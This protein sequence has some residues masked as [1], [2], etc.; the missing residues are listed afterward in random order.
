MRPSPVSNNPI[1]SIGG[2]VIRRYEPEIAELIRA[3]DQRLDSTGKADICDDRSLEV[4]SELLI[5]RP[6]G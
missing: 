1:S 2:V 3:R 6:A 5:D 4:T